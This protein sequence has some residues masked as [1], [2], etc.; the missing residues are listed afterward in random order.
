MNKFRYIQEPNGGFIPQYF[1][2]KEVWEDFKVKH[3]PKKLRNFCSEIVEYDYSN[4]IR[5]NKKWWHFTSSKES[6]EEMSL[7]F[8]DEMVVNAFL[9]AAK[10]CFEEKVTNF[11]L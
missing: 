2:N 6:D 3:I 8:A 11:E 1:T 9:G 5:S 10:H 4:N 7:V